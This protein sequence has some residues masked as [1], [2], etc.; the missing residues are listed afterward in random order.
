MSIET[1]RDGAENAS[2]ETGL[3]RAVWRWHFY[4]GLFSLPFMILLAVTGGLYLFQNEL[5]RILYKP[6]MVVAAQTTSPLNASDLIARAQMAIDGAAVRYV[7]A[8]EPTDAVEIGIKGS[9]K[10]TRSVYVNPYTG[11]VLGAIGDKDKVMWIVRKLHSLKYFGTAPERVIEIVGGWAIIL[12]ITGFYLWWP[13]KQTGGVVTIRSTPKKRVFWRD[14]HAVTGA[15][16]GIFIFFLAFTGM[17]W[18]GFWGNN[19]N[20][21]VNNHGLGYPPEFWDDVPKSTVPMKDALTE[22]NWTLSNQPMPV[23]ENHG[24]AP[25]GIDEAIAIFNERGI[26]KGYTIDLPGGEDG[27][28]S[29]S[30]FGGTASEER[31]IHLDQY[32]GKPL[33]DGDFA[34]IGVGAKGIEWHQRSY[35]PRV[36]SHQQA[37]HGSRLCRHRFDG[38]CSDCDVVEAAAKGFIR[39]TALSVRCQDQSRDFADCSGDW[40]SLSTGRRVADCDADHRQNHAAIAVCSPRISYTAQKVATARG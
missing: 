39:R 30:A 24:T 7:P 1:I 36:W 14:L 34:S 29:A 23:S 17:P 15:F 18:S 5:N 22:T 31:V 32:T 2:V 25:I 19:F 35:G 4:A 28:Y 8:T 20:N 11:D 37:H 10:V 26:A 3:Y 21:F 12:V 6:L 40:H 16:A 9:D 38:G 13:R 27:V 33:F